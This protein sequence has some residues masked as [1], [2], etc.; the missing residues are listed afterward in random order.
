MS[1][2]AGLD[3]LVNRRT[4]GNSGTPE[5]IWWHK[6]DRIGGVTITPEQQREMSLWMHDG[7]PS[8]AATPTTVAIPDNTTDG[9]FKQA[10]PGGGRQKWLNAFGNFWSNGQ[11]TL[12]LYDRLLHIGG[13]S[14]LLPTAQ[15]VGGTIT[16]YTGSESYG[17][18][19]F[20][21]VNADI[22]ATAT[23]ISASYT[24]E[25]GTSGQTTPTTIFG[26]TGFRLQG[27]FI[28]LP[29]ASGDMGVR[30][31]ADVTLGVSTGTTGDF[32][33]VIAR[34]VAMVTVTQRGGGG[35]QTF[36]ERISEIKSDACLAMYMISHDTQTPRFG[37]VVSMVEA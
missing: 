12:V 21:E 13:L 10:T 32:G 20:A 18:Q 17:N 6:T 7:Y 19:L 2:L 14:G 23:T 25:A 1:A 27:R 26:G 11:C 16:R 3:D 24:N 5:N 34:P 37:G 4:G 15:T 9:G 36:L 29:L 22:G 31:V 8:A 35:L 28:Q 33:I 30:A